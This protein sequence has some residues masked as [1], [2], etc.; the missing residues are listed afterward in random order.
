MTPVASMDALC[1]VL[2]QRDVSFDQ[3]APRLV[4]SN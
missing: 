4:E 3:V 1:D 2:D